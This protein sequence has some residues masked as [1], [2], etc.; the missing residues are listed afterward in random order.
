MILDWKQYEEKAKQAVAEGVVLLK[1]E[2]DVLPLE[3]KSRVSV[4]GRMQNNYYKSG[5]GSGGMVNVDK[6]W[7]VMDALEQEDIILNDRLKETYLAFEQKVPFNKGM[8]FGNEPW[9]QPEMPIEEADVK[10]AADESEVAIVILGRTAGEEQDFTDTP[11]AY[12]LSELEVELLRKVRCH[13]SKMILL[14][15]VTAPLDMSEIHS[16]SPDAVMMIWAGGEIGGLGTA[17]VL[18]GRISPSGHLSDTILHSLSDASAHGYFGDLKENRYAEDIYV[19]YRYYETFC[20][21][22]VLYPFGYGLSY[23]TFEIK[24]GEAVFE[25][26][27]VDGKDTVE[28]KVEVKNTGNRSGKEVVQLYVSVPQGKLGQ[29]SLALVAFAKTKELAPGESEWITLTGC[30]YYFASYDDL[31]V[32]GYPHAYVHEAGDYR[33]FAGNNVRD[34]AEVGRY[35]LEQNELVQQLSVQ[36]APVKGFQRIRPQLAEDGSYQIAWEEVPAGENVDDQKAREDQPDCKPYTGDRGIK[37]W[38]VR[39]KKASMDDFLAQLSEEDL[40]AIV[41]AEGM[42]SPR[43]TPGTAAAFGGVSDRLVAYGIPAA[44]CSDGPSGMRLDCGA[45]AFSLPSGTLLACTWNTKLNQE[46]Y[47]FLSLEM[48]KN[49][50]DV[51]LGPGINIHRYPLNGRNFEY[52]SEDPYLTGCMASAQIKGLQAAGNTGTIKHFCAN[53]QEKCRQSVDSIVSERALRQIYLKGFEIAVRGGADSVMTT[54]GPVNGIWTNSRHDLNT[55]ILRREWGFTGIVMTDWWADIG[56]LEHGVSKNDFARMV[57]AGNDFYAVCPE[58]GVNSTGD[59]LLEELEEGSLGRGQLV[60]CAANICGFLM[61]TNAMTRLLKEDEK[62]ELVNY[63]ATKKEID[64]SDVS[65]VKISDGTCLDLT[66]QNTDRGSEYVFGIDVME[67]GFY[68]MSFTGSSELSERSQI[69]VALFI[70]NIPIANFSFHGTGGEDMTLDTKLLLNT[71]YETVRIYFA[72]G[73][74]TAKQIKFTLI[75][76]AEE[77]TEEEIAAFYHSFSS[78]DS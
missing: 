47:A 29:P 39:D 60:R 21:E 27:E 64:P 63:T 32:T 59:N 51:L 17:D 74:L 19:G 46:L 52:F 10:A 38:E 2:K 25:R 53:N 13:F 23:T 73:G 5:T 43:V 71:K 1:N 26:K 22:K 16:I 58:A 48:Y 69:N 72:G 14:L 67:K 7:G 35:T 34:V 33:F 15:N 11:G 44:C 24:T 75:K 28:V 30:S 18:M 54:Y 55:E 57:R 12:R 68:R 56:D 3:K 20:K 49:H 76:P 6:V 37:L 70:Q 77:I 78:E 42:G 31:G 66:G 61:H 8:G 41:R 4:F 9:S 40:A 36:M 45:R 65:Y 62:M 50:V